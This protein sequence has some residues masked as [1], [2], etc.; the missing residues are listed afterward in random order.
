VL[1]T[2]EPFLQAVCGLVRPSAPVIR[3][4]APELAV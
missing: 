4:A 1:F 3:A 2:R